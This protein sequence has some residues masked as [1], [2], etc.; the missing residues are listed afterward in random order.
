[1]VFGSL[2][3]GPGRTQPDCTRAFP[4]RLQAQRG[5]LHCVGAST[6][7]GGTYNENSGSDRKMYASPL[8]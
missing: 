5:G 2:L 7:G 3:S 1:M 4:H 8:V 6:L